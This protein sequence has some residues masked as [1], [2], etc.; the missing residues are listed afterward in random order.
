MNNNTEIKFL[1]TEVYIHRWPLDSPVWC[2]ER[3]KQI[4]SQF[5]QNKEKKRIEILAKSIR[6]EDLEFCSI[7]KVGISIPMF[8]K[9]NT[10]IFEGNCQEF[11]AHI[12]VTT[13][14][15]DY[16]QVFEKISAWRD[17]YFPESLN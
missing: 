3:K 12:H 16:L 8:K 7:K 4:D 17:K 13:K 9:Q 11:D 15:D 6:I 1:S 2:E 5:N 14:E 10:L